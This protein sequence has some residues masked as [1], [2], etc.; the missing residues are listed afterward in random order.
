VEASRRAT[1]EDLPRLAELA[2]AGAAELLSYRGGEV[3]GAR[4][5]RREPVEEGLAAA[6]QDPAQLVVAGT[7]D[8]VV[9]G[10]AAVRVE[11]LAD[12][13]RLG[14]ID[15]LFVE[16]GARAVGL[17]E[18]LMDD[19]LAWCREQGCS[20]VDATA[21]PGHRTTKNFFEESGFTARLLVMYRA[22]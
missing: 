3:W 21:L 9:L 4:H 17:G 12:G 10:F 13:R 22:L 5:G 14:A 6:L 2:R 15:E 8:E 20:G 16:E 11:I 1:P 19:V 7:I 18:A